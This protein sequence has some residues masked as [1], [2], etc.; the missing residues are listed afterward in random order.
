MGEKQKIRLFFSHG[1]ILSLFL[2]LPWWLRWQGI[3]V[4]VQETLV[5]SLRRSPGGGMATHSSNLAWKIPWTEEPGG[6]QSMGSQRVR[7]D[8]ANNTFTFTLDSCLEQWPRQKGYL[9][10]TE[11]N[12][13]LTKEILSLVFRAQSRWSART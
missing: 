8:R 12:V 11:R 9:S 4:A 2:W 10:L 3:C 13:Q 5:R 1:F 6:L 7:H